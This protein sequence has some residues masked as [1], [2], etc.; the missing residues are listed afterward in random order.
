[1]RP[2]HVQGRPVEGVGT[3]ASCG[4]RMLKVLPAPLELADC[5]AAVQ[6]RTARVA[7][8]ATRELDVA[9]AQLGLDGDA[10]DARIERTEGGLNR[11]LVEK[12]L[13]HAPCGAVRDEAVPEDVPASDH[14]PSAAG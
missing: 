5:V 2:R 9:L 14:R 1:M 4:S 8:F 13:V 11:A 3:A 7:L 10:A 12:P 6:L